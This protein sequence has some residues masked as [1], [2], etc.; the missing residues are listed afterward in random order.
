MTATKC[1]T[2][3]HISSAGYDFKY[4]STQFR[5]FCIILCQILT[6]SPCHFACFE[7][8]C[9]II[10]TV[11][12]FQHH[13]INFLV[14]PQT[15]QTADDTPTRGHAALHQHQQGG[16]QDCQRGG[17]A[18]WRE[19]G[20]SSSTPQR[21]RQVPSRPSALLGSFTVGLATSFDKMA[22]APLREALPA[23]SFDGAL[24]LYIR[25]QPPRLT[26][27]CCV[28]LVSKYH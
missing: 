5:S 4:D 1:L 18:P 9:T 23:T 27:L 17:H 16:H 10:R 2:L 3:S 12:I 22:G 19:R 8:K 20:P 14:D 13:W 26:R 25:S 28:T 15:R 7:I 21:S 6:F 11:Y 24:A